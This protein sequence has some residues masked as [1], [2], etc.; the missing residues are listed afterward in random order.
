MKRK[1]LEIKKEYKNFETSLLKRG[2]L[3]MWDTGIGY[4]S[5]AELKEV[6]ELFQ[7]INL[8]RYKNFLD[9]GS[10]DGRV[11]LTASLFTN[12]TG[13][14]IDPGL[15]SKSL[16]MKEKLKLPASF[17]NKNYF[18]YHIGKHDLVFL[19]PDQPLHRGI[20]KKLINELKGHLVVYGHHFHP[21]LLIKQKAFNI[22]NNYIALYSP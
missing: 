8:S 1:F 10:G 7:K 6:F 19:H 14:E 5:S 11:V 2:K 21:T 13:I 3:P 18:D 9:L 17:I 12:A 16:Q 15:F 20:E 4:Y 22:N